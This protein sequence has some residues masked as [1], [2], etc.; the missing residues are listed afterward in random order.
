[1]GGD[2]RVESEVG[3]GSTFIIYIPVRV[4]DTS[5]QQTNKSLDTFAT[6]KDNPNKKNTI[7]VIDDDP[8]IHDLL[9]RFL[10]KKGFEVKTATSGTE[11]IELAKKL[12]PEAIT[13]DVMMPG[14]DGWSVLASLKAHPQTADIPVIM[15]TMV[16]DQN[17]GYALGAAEYLLKPI[18]SK[19]LET[20]LD[21][22]KPNS[23]SNSILVVED[24]PGI[25]EMLCRQLRSENWK[26]IQAENGKEALLKLKECHSIPGLILSDLM[27][28]EMDGFELVHRLKKDTRLK[29]IP[30]IILTAKTITNQDRQKLN[31]GVNKIFEKG[32]YQRSILF[33][34]VSSLL[35]NA[36]ARQQ[37]EANYQTVST[38]L[39]A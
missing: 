16:D 15:M 23:D 12:K 38:S 21:K 8:T 20:I 13:L 34:E 11:G 9:K 35:D 6:K 32:S 4:V 22:F 36:L 39:S 28:P 10:G 14:M 7:L 18:D 1:M 2:I 19:K 30:V 37:N 25:R 31:G 3:V 26:V 24:D 33:D 29:N 5:K 17:L 27:M